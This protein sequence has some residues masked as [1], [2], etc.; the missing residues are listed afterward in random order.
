MDL[1]VLS[2]VERNRREF[3]EY[4]TLLERARNMQ[5][6]KPPL[7][8]MHGKILAKSLQDSFK[9]AWAEGRDFHRVDVVP[10]PPSYPPSIQPLD[11]LKPLVISRMTLGIRQRGHRIAVLVTTAGY[12]HGG[13]WAVAEDEEATE[14]F[15]DLYHQPEEDKVGAAWILKPGDICFI[16]EPFLQAMRTRRVLIINHVSDIVWPHRQD[17][18]IPSLWRQH[19]SDTPGDSHAIRMQGNT[20]VQGKDWA[21]AEHLLVN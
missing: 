12:R 21:G 15:V 1:K 2:E 16:K 18:R 13:A 3:K 10:L 14:V 4:R 8:D 19:L 20:Q 17:E 7:H 6:Q 11:E 5:G 9:V